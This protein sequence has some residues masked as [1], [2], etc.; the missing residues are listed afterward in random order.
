MSYHKLS[1]PGRQFDCSPHSG[2]I[3]FCRDGSSSLVEGR[4]IGFGSTKISPSQEYHLSV[5]KK[6]L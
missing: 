1:M 3:I 4:K 2:N 6:Y 5:E